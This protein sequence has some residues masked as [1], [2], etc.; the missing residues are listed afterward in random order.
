MSYR[1]EYTPRTGVTS[2][3]NNGYASRILMTLTVFALFLFVLHNYFP[4][5]WTG[6]Q[7]WLWPGDPAVTQSALETM[8]A[9]LKSGLPFSHAAAAFCTEIFRN[10]GVR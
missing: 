6:L 5:Y 4:A 7:G 1:I 9:D 3:E 8:V 2:T 10:A